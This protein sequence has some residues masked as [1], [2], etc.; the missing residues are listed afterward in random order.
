M[1]IPFT[2]KKKY[3][4]F[5]TTGKLLGLIHNKKKCKSKL[6]Y[7]TISHLLVWQILKL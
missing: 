4:W 6:H 7:D 5:L 1:K 2:K 3:V